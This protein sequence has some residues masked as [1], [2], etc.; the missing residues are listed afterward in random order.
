MD[1]L[2]SILVIL[3][4]LSGTSYTQTL[5]MSE[6][7]SVHYENE[8]LKEVLTDLGTSYNIP[9]AYSDDIVPDN[10]RVTLHLENQPVATVLDEL[11]AETPIIYARIGDQVVLKKNQKKYREKIGGYEDDVRLTGES[12][13]VNTKV[14]RAEEMKT[15][16]PVQISQRNIKLEERLASSSPIPKALMPA[17]MT[18]F[19]IDYS[20]LDFAGIKGL[21]E[22]I[23][24][25]G[26]IVDSFFMKADVDLDSLDFN[27]NVIKLDS[28]TS[29]V[30]LFLPTK[31]DVENRDT[32][33]VG[34]NIFKGHSTTVHGVNI[35]GVMNL[36]EEEVEGALIAGIRNRVKGNVLGTQIAGI[37]NKVGHELIGSQIAGISNKA[38]DMKGAQIA[39]ISNIARE[40][41]DGAQLAIGFNKANGSKAGAQ[42][43]VL[44]N[45]SKGNM[46]AQ[47]AVLSNNSKGNTNAQVAVLSNKADTIQGAQVGLTNYAT[48]VKGVQVGLINS[49]KKASVQ[50][51]LIN[52]AK[53][54]SVP[55]GLLSF[56]KNGYNRLEIGT[57]TDFEIQAGLK[58]GAKG[59]YNILYAA[60][61]RNKEIWGVGYGIGTRLKIKERW[62]LNWELISTHIN[63]NEDW[64]WEINE[65]V[66]LRTTLEFKIGKK[67]SCYLGP[68]VNNMISQYYDEDDMQFETVLEPGDIIYEKTYTTASNKLTRIQSWLGL[69][70]G[71]RF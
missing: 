28:F 34:M 50:I 35:S 22:W 6:R 24:R 52:F 60:T 49:A 23:N 71:L 63:E 26:S 41:S 5:S 17:P 39:L 42:L 44:S 57:G 62:G 15:D 29:K 12:K 37:S 2:I 8:L 16:S 43:A 27:V 31:K 36:V 3:I 40:T 53:E 7:I 64:L 67:F 70:G 9:L 61:N 59:F 66:K 10:T 13:E 46:N 25:Q 4:G 1:K 11:F 38:D 14:Y 65:L 56:V 68:E 32:V 55:I 21:K 58:V 54:S 19:E 18:G 33:K 30:K 48:K 69:S 51:G 45:R 47:V 20:E